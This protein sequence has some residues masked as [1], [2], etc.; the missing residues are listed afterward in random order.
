[1]N[2]ALWSPT[3]QAIADSRL[4]QFSQLVTRETG[5]NFTDYNAL[6]H[7]SVTAPEQFWQLAWQYFWKFQPHYLQYLRA[8]LV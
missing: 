3:A 1:M 5:N 2:E 7:W 4:T 6:H 8:Q